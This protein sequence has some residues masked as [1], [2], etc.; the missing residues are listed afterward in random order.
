MNR[1]SVTEARDALA[2]AL[3]RVAYAGER[4]V[5]ERHGKSLAALIPV[6]DLELLEELENRADLKAARKALREKGRVPWEDVKKRNGL[7]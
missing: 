6:E 2:E 1:L 4:I 7:A 5:L 3:N